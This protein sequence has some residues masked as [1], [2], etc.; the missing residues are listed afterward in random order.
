MSKDTIYMNHYIA[1]YKVFWE[2]IIIFQT[3]QNC[4]FIV[5]EIFHKN[6]Q[7]IDLYLT[8]RVGPVVARSPADRG[9]RGSN[10]TLA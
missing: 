7:T 1:A 10:P 9:V 5:Q 4:K 8:G 3:K 2:K 6:N